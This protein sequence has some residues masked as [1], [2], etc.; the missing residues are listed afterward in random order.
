MISEEY[1]IEWLENFIEFREELKPCPFCGREAEIIDLGDDRITIQT[2]CK[3]TCLIQDTGVYHE[4]FK[5]EL[6]D[7]WNTRS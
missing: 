1:I 4:L 5:D 7:K 3:N 6:I 2:K